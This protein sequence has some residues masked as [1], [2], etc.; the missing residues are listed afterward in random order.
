MEAPEKQGTVV[1]LLKT[2]NDKENAG[3]KGKP[4]GGEGKG[5]VETEAERRV[6]QRRDL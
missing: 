6:R 4:V 2:V 1:Q 5:K 3:G